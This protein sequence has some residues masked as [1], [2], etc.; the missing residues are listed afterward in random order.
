MKTSNLAALWKFQELLG[1]EDRDDMVLAGSLEGDLPSEDAGRDGPAA[2]R[3]DML[4]AGLTHQQLT[5][6]LKIRDLMLL[7]N[8]ILSYTADPTLNDVSSTDRAFDPKNWYQKYGGLSL[9]LSWSLSSLIPGSEADMAK[10]ELSQQLELSNETQKRLFETAQREAKIQK[11]LLRDSY[12][13]FGN[14]QSAVQDSQRALALVT[15]AY[16]SGTGRLLD[17]QAAEIALQGVEMQLLNER[18]N[19]MALIGDYQAKFCQPA[20]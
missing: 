13:K 3:F 19:L 9:T 8:L 14:Q 10:R 1:F 6:G 18:L 11:L 15:I 7:P 5:N 17:L 20:R 2:E 12:A 4:E 16:D